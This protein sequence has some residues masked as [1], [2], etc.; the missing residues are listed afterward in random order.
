LDTIDQAEPFHDSNSGSP[1]ADPRAV[2]ALGCGHDTLFKKLLLAPEFGLGTTD[3]ATPF[4]CSTS[5][6]LVLTPAV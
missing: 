6:W 5:V 4:H 2:H 1:A 3:Q